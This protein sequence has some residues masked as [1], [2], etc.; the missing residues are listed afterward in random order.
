[1][2]LLYGKHLLTAAGQYLNIPFSLYKMGKGKIHNGPWGYKS[3]TRDNDTGRTA[4]KV[5]SY[6]ILRC[7]QKTVCLLRLTILYVGY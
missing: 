7:H 3:L 1:M 4:W 5:R 2:K 6:Y